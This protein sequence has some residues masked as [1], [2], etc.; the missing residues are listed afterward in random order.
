MI[1]KNKKITSAIVTLAFFLSLNGLVY[2]GDMPMAPDSDIQKM[3]SNMAK[4]ME[5]MK[6]LIE[7]QNK[8]IEYLEQKTIDGVK[9]GNAGSAQQAAQPISEKDFQD[10]LKNEIKNVGYFKNLKM[11][12]DFR[13]RYEGFREQNSNQT[14]TSETQALNAPESRNRF[15]YR[16]RYGIE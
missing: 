1:F 15:R 9:L 8:K 16:L 6:R 4:E 5:Q 12:G 11:G 14:S 13:L 7:N 3:V 10:M 2:A